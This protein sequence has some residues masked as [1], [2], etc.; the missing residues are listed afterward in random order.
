MD[1]I[2]LFWDQ[3]IGGVITLGYDQWSLSKSFWLMSYIM[4]K[5]AF[6]IGLYFTFAI[7]RWIWFGIRL[8]FVPISIHAWNHRK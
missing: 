3:Y 1:W 7:V 5:L 6:V 4:S 2:N 8:V